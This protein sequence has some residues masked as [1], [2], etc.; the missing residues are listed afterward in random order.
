M[1]LN[2]KRLPRANARLEI[3]TQT[4]TD[5]QAQFLE[6]MKLREQVREAQLSA[7]LQT[8]TRARKPAPVVI[9]AA[10]WRAS[11]AAGKPAVTRLRRVTG[12]RLT[13]GLRLAGYGENESSDSPRGSV[14]FSIV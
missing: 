3:L 1:S 12:E 14:G 6:L 8:A 2:L 4:E 11:P 7:D 13:L 10:A 9:A 5:L